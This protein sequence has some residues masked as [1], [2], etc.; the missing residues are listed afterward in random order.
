MC[1]LEEDETEGIRGFAYQ[2]LE[3]FQTYTVTNT[4]NFAGPKE[5]LKV[6][7]A[8]IPDINEYD[9][10]AHDSGTYPE[11]LILV[12]HPEI[13]NSHLMSDCMEILLMNEN[14]APNHSYNLPFGVI[15]KMINKV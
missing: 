10:L 8:D 9:S 15:G 3:K 4:V 1:D 12:P 13:E 6:V 14:G 5:Y 7:E 11:H 2:E